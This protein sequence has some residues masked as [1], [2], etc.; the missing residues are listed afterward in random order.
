MNS[1]V[2]G[3]FVTEIDGVEF[4]TDG[5]IHSG[6]SFQVSIAYVDFAREYDSIS[7]T[8]SWTIGASSRF[9]IAN[10]DHTGRVTVDALPGVFD[11][12]VVRYAD[13]TFG[14]HGGASIGGPLAGAS[15][16]VHGGGD[17]SGPHGNLSTY[18]H[19]EVYSDGTL[20]NVEYSPGNANYPHVMVTRTYHLPDGTTHIEYTNVA[21]IQVAA[22]MGAGIAPQIYEDDAFWGRTE[23]FGP[24]TPIDMWP[25]DPEFAPD[26]S[27]PNKIFDQDAVR[28][29]IWKKPIVMIRKGDVVVSFDKN[30]NLM[31]G[32]VTRTFENES[33]ILLDYFGT[34]VTPGHVYFRP[35]SKKA[36]KFECLL[37]I[38]REDGMIQN[39]EGKNIRAATNVP[40]GAPRD[41][42]VW[43]ITQEC[44]DGILVEKQRE[45]IRLG[46][47]FIVDDKTSQ[48]VADVIEAKGGT[49]GGDE[50]IRFGADDPAPFV[51]EHGAM[52]P[53][54]EDFVLQVSGTTLTD[55]YKAGEWESRRPH[56]PA[57]LVMDGGP[58]QPLSATALSAMPR[59]QPLNLQPASAPTPKRIA[60]PP[61][62]RKQRKAMEAKQRKAARD[63][64]RLVS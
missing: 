4:Y 40:I 47:R 30:D 34:R 24:E 37:D 9:P 61:M 8:G 58:V 14:V 41:G 20:V 59:N 62:N 42:F 7:N 1:G 19:I 22:D 27:N 28:A 32:R 52:L 29:K 57:P 16:S 44:K 17:S 55:I 23:C 11:V 46:T 36:D 39:V 21:D 53:K 6:S 48:C 12:G 54:P 51:W 49:V 45:R 3:T 38:L 63:K 15:F 2:N 64:R 33:K 43:A 10:V 5:V 56:M 18:D 13:G 35:D 31:P 26:P 60:R 50:L 25:L